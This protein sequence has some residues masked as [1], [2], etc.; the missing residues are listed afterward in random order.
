MV[1]KVRKIQLLLSHYHSV[2]MISNE[3]RKRVEGWGLS[4]EKELKAAA[5]GAAGLRKLEAAG[6]KVI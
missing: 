1:M 5:D 6:R 4:A 3:A 2:L